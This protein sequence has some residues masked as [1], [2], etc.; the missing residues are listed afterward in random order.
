MHL[1][2]VHNLY[3]SSLSKTPAPEESP[4]VTKFQCHLCSK[5]LKMKG[6][7]RIHMKVAHIGFQNNDQ[8]VNICDYLKLH[9]ISN[10]AAKEPGTSQGFSQPQQFHPFEM[11]EDQKPIID[12]DNNII[13]MANDGSYQFAN[14]SNIQEVKIEPVASPSNSVAKIWS[15]DVCAK[16]FTTKYFL[17][18]HNRLHTGTQPKIEKNS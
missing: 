3:P 1:N 16:S 7:L 4:V 18:K 6:S 13:S 17:K 9:K 12:L 5:Y 14:T 10:D 11:N 8:K 2:L 15:C